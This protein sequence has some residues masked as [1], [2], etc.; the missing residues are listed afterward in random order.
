M[1]NAVRVDMAMLLINDVFYRTWG[2]NLNSHGW[3]RP[4]EEYWVYT[5]SKVKQ[6]H[7]DF[8]FLAEGKIIFN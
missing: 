8:K 4:N 3:G 7:K 5:I 1:C 6:V 2:Q